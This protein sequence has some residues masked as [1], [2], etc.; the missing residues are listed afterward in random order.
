[1]VELPKAPKVSDLVDVVVALDARVTELEGIASTNRARLDAIDERAG[2]IRAAGR[3]ELE[4]LKRQV[5]RERWV[6]GR[7]R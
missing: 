1:M 5:N 7:R 4:H 6:R 3:R 2:R